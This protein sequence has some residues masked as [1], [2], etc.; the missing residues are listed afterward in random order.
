MKNRSISCEQYDYIEI[1]CMKRYPIKLL[2]KDGSEIDCIAIDTAVN[3]NGCECVKVSRQDNNSLIEL[4]EIA[5]LSVC[6][7]NP[8][9]DSLTF[10]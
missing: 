10:A 6:V 3:D 1:V 4:A 9:F 8:Y 2:M 5:K 7:D